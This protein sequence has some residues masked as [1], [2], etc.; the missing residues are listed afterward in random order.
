MIGYVYKLATGPFQELD[1]L[2]WITH[3]AVA[4][5]SYEVIQA[6]DFLTWVAYT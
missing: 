1:E 4:P 2:Q 5:M 6:K 3:E